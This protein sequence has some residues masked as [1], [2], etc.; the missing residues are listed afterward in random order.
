VSI[1]YLPADVETSGRACSI[2]RVQLTLDKATAGLIDADNRQALACVSH[3]SEVE[4][5]IGGW[6]NFIASERIRYLQRRQ[7]SNL[8]YGGGDNARLNP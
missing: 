5:L 3:F 4:L 6:A 2:C 8:I 1:V 7:P